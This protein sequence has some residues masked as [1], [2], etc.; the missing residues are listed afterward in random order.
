MFHILQ[1]N[2]GASKFKHVGLPNPDLCKN[3]FEKSSVT[4][5]LGYNS[6]EMLPNIDAEQDIEDQFLHP[7]S[8]PSNA[9]KEAF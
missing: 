2:P 7:D 6:S 1:A 4:G 9:D 8:R 5:G 3:I